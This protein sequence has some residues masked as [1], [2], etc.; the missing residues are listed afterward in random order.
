MGES[1]CNILGEETKKKYENCAYYS[2]EFIFNPIKHPNSHYFKPFSLEAY[3]S[4]FFLPSFTSK[5]FLLLLFESVMRV[6]FSHKCVHYSVLICV[7]LDVY[8]EFEREW[9]RVKSEK[10]SERGREN[11]EM[12]FWVFEFWNSL[13]SPLK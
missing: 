13:C 7:F 3:S 5:V 10:E 2:R 8:R 12:Y 11:V 6:C 4:C 1:L 9:D